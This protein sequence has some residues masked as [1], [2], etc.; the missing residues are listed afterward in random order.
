MINIANINNTNIFIDTLK[1][2]QQSLSPLTK[3][4]TE[5]EKEAIKKL[6][7]QYIVNWDY[8]STLWENLDVSK[9][10]KILEIIAGGK[11][12]I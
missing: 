12:I 4:A 9:K 11:G 10:F 6:A 7:L 2:C 8:F 5:E 1:Y 3:T